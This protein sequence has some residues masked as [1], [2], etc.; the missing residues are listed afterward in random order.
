MTKQEFLKM[1]KSHMRCNKNKWL[2]NVFIVDA[3]LVKIKL[4]NKY[5]QILEIDGLYCGGYEFQTQKELI[6]HIDDCFE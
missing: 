4:F 5:L 6:Q 1:I 2:M 3:H